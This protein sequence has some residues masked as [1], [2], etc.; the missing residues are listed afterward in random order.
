M[1]DATPV[2]L[3]DDDAAIRQAAR[4]WLEL[5]GFAVTCFA[6]AEPAL[7]RL[8]PD[9]PGVAVCDLRMPGLDGM[10]LLRQLT[11]R[12]ADL[13]VVMITG[14]G[15]VPA[16]VEAMRA[17]AYDF[18]EKPFEPEA[19]VDTL[20]RAAEKRRLVSENRTLRAALA[21][22]EGIEG[23]LLGNGPEMIELR[24]D[25]GDLAALSAD[26]LICGETGTGKELVA[27]CLHDFGPRKEAPFVAINCGAVPETIFESEVFGH[28]AGAFTGA[29]TARVGKFEFADGGTV[30]LDEVESLPL[31][32]QV[33]LLRF[34]QER[35][36][37]PLGSNRPRPVD[38]RVVA[39]TKTELR[40]LA[41][42]G[43]F[44]PDLY[45]RLNVAELHLPPLR[46]RGDDASALFSHFL[47]EAAARLRLP[48]PTLS[49]ADLAALRGHD[50]P[51]N[52]R[53]LR[54]CAERFL[55]GATRGRGLSEWLPGAVPDAAPA[56]LAARLQA[57]ERAVI[58]AALQRHRGAIKAVLD[59]LDLPRRT[60]NEKMQRHGI[61][62]RDYRDLSAKDRP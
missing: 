55:I 10:D 12:D 28:E 40:A 44:R 59:E 6:R 51:G 54:N 18:L 11:R 20:R 62:R 47:I 19:L 17:G 14:H 43:K 3:I 41:D 21:A 57:Y 4:Q 26:V 34:L 27:R 33:K 49:S 8:G 16:A 58:V 50:W 46:A 25:I 23:R 39:A 31:A 2:V 61:D 24:R 9:F 52:V 29:L 53:E 38:V 13:P 45:Y 7:E 15:D 30:F 56:G 22:G 42:Q 32:L 35:C 1:A 5:A 60:L 48:P 37:E 36:V